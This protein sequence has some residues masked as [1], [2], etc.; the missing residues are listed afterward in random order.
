MPCVLKMKIRNLAIFLFENA[1][2]PNWDATGHQSQTC[3]AGWCGQ[4]DGMRH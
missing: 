2:F 1:A 3:G 4:T